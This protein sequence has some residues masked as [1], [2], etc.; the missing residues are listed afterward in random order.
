MVSLHGSAD[1]LSANFPLLTKSGP[2]G[3]LISLS[4]QDAPTCISTIHRLFAAPDV[5]REEGP[6]SKRRKVGGGGAVAI[7]PQA[8]FDEK[9]S[10]VLAKISIDL[11]MPAASHDSMDMAYTLIESEEP[12]LVELESIYRERNSRQAFQVALWNVSNNTGVDIVATTSTPFLDSIVTHM[13]TAATLATT[14]AGKKSRPVS[15]A[16][17]C[18]CQLYQPA[19]GQTSYK[20]DVEIRWTLSLSVV[21]DPSVRG[22]YMNEDLKLLSTYLSDA[23]TQGDKT[24]TLSDFYDS[25][26]VP[27]AELK[28]SPRIKQALSATSLLP[29]Q[30]RTVDWLLRREGVAFSSSGTLE[31]FVNTSPPAS[32]RPAHDA[33]GVPCYTSQLRGAVVTDLDA[34][35]GDT[36]QALRGGILAEEMGLGKTLEL[37]ALISHHPR[38]IHE[39]KIYDEYTGIDVKPSGA[40]LI[41]T[42]SSILDQWMTEIHNHAPELKVCH[43]KGIPSLNASKEDHAA[44]TVDHLMQYDVVL[45]TYQVLTKEIHHA[46]PPPDRSSRRAKTRERR[47]SPLVGISWWRLCLDEAQM[48]E[49]GVSQAAKVARIIPRCNAWAVSGTPLRKDIQDLRGLLIFLRC[50]AFANNRAVWGRLD[51]ASFRGIF[52]EIALRNTKY[53]VRNELQLP[54]QKRIV[55]TVPFTTIEEQHY[56]DLIRQMCDSCWLT[57]DGQP[58]V[59]DR[60][61]SD[62]D[63]IE[64]MRDW[65]VRLRQTCLHVNVGRRNRRALGAKNGALRT[66]HEVLEVMIEQTDTKWKSSAREMILCMIKMGHIHAY[67][68]EFVARAESA[69]P[70]Y[71]AAHI[72][73]AEYIATCREEL[74]EEEQKLGRSASVGLGEGDDDDEADSSNLGRIP[75][76]RKSLRSFLELDHAAHFFTATTIHQIKENPELTEPDSMLWHEKDRS[77]TSYYEKAKVVR[78]ELL[79]HSKIKA[80]RQM[81]KIDAKKPF[82]QIPKIEDLPDLGGIEAREILDTMDHI[83]DFL[84]AQAEQIQAWRTKIV[85]I[86]LTRLVD[87][88]DDQETTGEEYDDSLKAQDELYVYIMALRTLIADRNAAVNGLQDTLIEHELKAAEKQATNK[89]D[90]EDRGHAPELVIEVANTR[91]KLQATLQPGSLKG[92][93]SGVRSLINGLQ[94]RA[95]N[96]DYRASAELS[97][98]QKHITRIQAVTSEQIK[99]IAELEKEQET[100]RGTMNQRLEYYRQFQHISDTVAKYQEDLDEFFNKREFEKTQHARDVKKHEAASHKARYTYLKYLRTEDQNEATAECIICRE[101]IELGVLTTCGHKYCKDCINTWWRAHRTCPTCKQKLGS[102]DFKDISFKPSEIKA[103]EEIHESGSQTQA[104]TPGS[105]STASIYSDIS[106]STMREIKMIDLDG[107]YGTK[108]DMIARHLI[109]IRKNDPGAKSVI[110]SQFGDFLAVLRNALDKWKIGASSIADKDGIRKFKTDQSVECLLLDAK[111]DSSGL[112]LVNATYVFLCEPLINPAIELQ[113]INRVHRIGQQRPTTVFMYLIS[114]TVEEAIYDISVTRRLEHMSSNDR[115]KA[116][117]RSGSAAPGLKEQDLDAANSAELQSAPLKQLLRK[118]GDGEVVQEDDLWHC[119]FGKPK[120]ESQPVLERVVARELRAGAAEARLASAEPATVAAGDGSDDDGDVEMVVMPESSGGAAGAIPIVG[121]RRDEE[122]R[123]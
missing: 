113:A 72:E 118:K 66:V 121:A 104:S 87:D 60:D 12:I 17:F 82:H 122:V 114:D 33:T 31:S 78:R 22:H 73:A 110:F 79:K 15:R 80:K 83:S 75:V 48:V 2:A 65:L 37:I 9:K 70:Y 26:H 28:V 102:S 38:V 16:A 56:T 39:D 68:G 29:F 99:A 52:N 1:V 94:W 49:S 101:D 88:E 117:S 19:D 30:E 25:V 57:S 54:P 18:R 84:N 13:R 123:L 116:P 111:T 63:V 119:L 45:T 62:P 34:A 21:E 71:L 11:N 53:N 115:S 32:F 92:V 86:L 90:Q 81:D 96:G 51:K 93:V 61:I 36:L 27:P 91:R 5:S 35:K 43:Y 40:T 76:L 24:W 41:I 98:L 109:W 120:K 95:D 97:I 50:D 100:F 4:A 112:T 23:A 77:E 106:D 47:V 6:S 55:I 3:A 103:K 8:Q 42:P 46:V 7:K 10:I 74:A 44:S 85:D 64:R 105:S 67:A 69:L 108:V 14:R 20:L 89:D 58:I 107:S 59:D